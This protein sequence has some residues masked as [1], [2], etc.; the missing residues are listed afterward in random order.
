MAITLDGATIPNTISYAEA[1]M[2]RGFEGSVVGK[3]IPNKPVPMGE[4][5]IP[6][7]GDGFKLGVVGEGKAKPAS[8]PGIEKAVLRPLKTAGI[9]V[10]SEEVA[11]KN[12]G[13]MLDI[14]EQK[15]V[16]AV[17][18]AV[19]CLVLFGVDPLAGTK[20]A[21]QVYVNQTK[22]RV[23]MPGKDTVAEILAGYGLVDGDADGFA[24]DSR[25]RATIAMASQKNTIGPVMPNLAT[26]TDTVA[27]LPA[28]YGRVIGANKAKGFVG[29]WSKV[30]WGFASDIVLKQ[31]TEAS[32]VD[33]DGT[34][35]RLW[36]EN[37]IG[38]LVETTISATV[39]GVDENF[40]AYD[41]PAA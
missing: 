28:A 32:V 24:F 39:L 2:K 33:G 18:Y 23:E 3:L 27:G 29:D 11:R 40:A 30:H 41:A 1:V 31:S 13:G 16:Q 9:L 10:V 34:E 25:L 14:I 36:Q 8:D 21:N 22:S 7:I 20:I 19:D 35:H 12:P 26:A 37:K 5:I 17:S 38:Y 15:L 6:V 4:G